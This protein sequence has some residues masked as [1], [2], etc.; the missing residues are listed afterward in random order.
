M[1]SV[2]IIGMGRMGRHL[3]HK[4][5]QLGNDVMVV[6]RDA[7]VIEALSDQ[8][9]DANICDCTNEAVIRSLGVDNFDVCF[10]TIGEDFQASLVITSLLKKHG[11][12]RIVAKTNQ[13]IQSDLL[14]IIG[15]NEVV[16]P[17]V[18]IA[19]K[20]AV[21]YNADNIF[22]YEPLTGEYS[23]YEIPILASWVGQTLSGLNVRRKYRVNIIAVKSGETVNAIP[24]AE[25]AFREGDHIVVVGR[26]DDV[27]RLAAKA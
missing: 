4:M 17:E 15:A 24:D 10:V 12:R 11:A 3:A 6:D 23:V 20:L 2:L 26:S 13:H 1:K 18:E 22:A 5:Q 16:Y 19:E 25:Y 8:F 14:R 7:S 27:F 21:R 9:T